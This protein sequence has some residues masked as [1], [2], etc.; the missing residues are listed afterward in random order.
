MNSLPGRVAPR[1]IQVDDPV[2]SETAMRSTAS[3][4]G[5]CHDRSGEEVDVFVISLLGNEE[6]VRF[7]ELLS[8]LRFISSRTLTDRLKSLVALGLVEREEVM[9]LLG[10]WS[11]D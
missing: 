5:P 11:T 6:V 7:G 1:K 10:R 8:G 9:N 3:T 2:L 4:P